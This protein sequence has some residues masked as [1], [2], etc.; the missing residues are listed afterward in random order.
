[1]ILD[2]IIEAKKEEVDYLKQS[3]SLLELKAAIRDLPSPRDFRGAISGK[4]CAIIAEVKRRSPSHGILRKDF[5]SV[6]IASLYEK[7]GAASV[8][9]LT[10]KK[11]FGGEKSYLAEI[12]KTVRLPL[13][14]KDF[15]I[16]SYQI[17]ETRLLNGDALL[18]IAG[19]LKKEQLDEYLHLAESLGLSALVE[20]HSREELDNALT[21]GANIIGINNRNLKSFT[22]DLKTSLEITPHI[23]ADKI[24]ISESGIQ[25]R[26]DIDTLMKAGIRAFLIGETLM[27]SENIEK[28]LKEL[29]GKE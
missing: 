29:L 17:Y 25:T 24:I 19:I 23:P 7:C 13:L 21:S 18:L 15:I 4:A 27:R 6:S 9:V 28:K 1:M 8:S 2:N 22:T 14:R 10:D 5:D 26:K 11:F 3:R 12:K 16:D 20:V